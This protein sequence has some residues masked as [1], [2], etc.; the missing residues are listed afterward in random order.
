[1]FNKPPRIITTMNDPEGRPSVADY[2][3][4]AR[5]RMFP[6]GRL[7]WDSE[8]LLI[9]T[10]DGDFA[11][12]VSHPKNDVAK[13][14]MVKVDGQ[15]T[16]E[17]LQKLVRGVSIIGGKSHALFAEKA[18]RSSSDKYDWI[19]V[20]INEGRNRQIRQMFEKIGF[21]VMKLQRIAVGRLKI[22]TLEKGM[23]RI[24]TDEDLSRIFA[25]PKELDERNQKRAEWRKNN[26]DA[27]GE[28]SS[29]GRPGRPARRPSNGA[30][31]YSSPRA[32]DGSRPSRHGSQK[33]ARDGDTKPPRE[34]GSKPASEGEARPENRPQRPGGNPF[35]D[36]GRT[37]RNSGFGGPQRNERSGPRG[38]PRGGRR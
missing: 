33:P 19:K 9:L 27:D 34:D 16:H 10:N 4:K 21:D 38:G 37:S 30:R 17:H 15:P 31:K 29:G 32:H 36:G 3:A 24:L 2:F 25:Q 20:I 23:F 7:D 6:V 22:G 5:V 18:E 11:Q 1:M 13:T 8:G 14:Y 26:L 12:R 35:R 28:R